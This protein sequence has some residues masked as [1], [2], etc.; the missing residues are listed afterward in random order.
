[1]A[2]R[3]PTVVQTLGERWGKAIAERRAELS[4]SQSQ[5]AE[6][7]GV[8]QQT[9]SKIEAGDMIPADWLKAVL[10]DRLMLEPGELFSWPTR[11]EMP[12]SAA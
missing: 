1:M 11:A 4:F 7:A 12:G 5:L 9:I 3:Q 6:L 10:A 8:K 2:V